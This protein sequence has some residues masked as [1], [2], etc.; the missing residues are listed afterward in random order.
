[1]L[2]DEGEGIKRRYGVSTLPASFLID[3][4]GRVRSVYGTLE[5]PDMKEL[6]AA[7]ER[8]AGKP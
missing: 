4:S 1:M 2:M 6:A 3:A 8:L 7:I 5:E